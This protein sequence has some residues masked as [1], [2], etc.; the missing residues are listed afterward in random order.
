MFGQGPKGGGGGGGGG[1]AWWVWGLV[2]VGSFAVLAATGAVC[3][4][5]ARPRKDAGGADTYGQSN[6]VADKSAIA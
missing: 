5:K 1:L 6:P 2:G 3:Y 4:L